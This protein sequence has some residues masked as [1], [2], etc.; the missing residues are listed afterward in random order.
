MIQDDIKVVKNPG[1]VRI[2]QTSDWIT[3]PSRSATMKPGE[4]VKDCPDGH[5]A[6]LIEDG[7][8]ALGTD[9]F[10]GIIDAESTDTSMADGEVKVVTLITGTVLRGKANTA[11]NLTAANLLLYYNNNVLFNVASGAFTIDENLADDPNVNGLRI[12]AGDVKM[13]TLDVIPHF[14]VTEHAPYL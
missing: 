8:P 10:L 1:T 4:P 5:Q 9:V 7:D 12:I 2:Y 3:E 13:G 11:G 14:M 6:T